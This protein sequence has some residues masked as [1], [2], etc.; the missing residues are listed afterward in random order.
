M[1]NVPRLIPRP[2]RV[3]IERHREV[4]PPDGTRVRVEQVQ[5]VDLVRFRVGFGLGVRLR[6]RFGLGLG[7]VGA[8]A[9]D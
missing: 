5:R 8:G 1:C 3:L 4:V 6:V 7:W 9:Y 2:L